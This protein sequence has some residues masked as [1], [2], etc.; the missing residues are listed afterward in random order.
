VSVHEVAISNDVI[1]LG[2][3]LGFAGVIESGADVK[4]IIADGLVSVNDEIERRRVRQLPAGD[5]VTLGATRTNAGRM[6][7][8]SARITRA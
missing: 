7:A 8:L 6:V 5:T 1:R 2:Q 3:F 4:A